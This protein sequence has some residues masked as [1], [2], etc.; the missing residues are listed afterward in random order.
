MRALHLRC[1]HFAP[2]LRNACSANAALAHSYGGGLSLRELV[3]RFAEDQDVAF[4]PKPGRT[5]AG[6]QVYSFGRVSVVI[7]AARE[8]LMAQRADGDRAWVPA[9]ME[10]LLEM[11]V[12]RSAAR[13]APA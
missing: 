12:G 3:E 7:D 4:L 10:Q 1:M 2:L 8:A 11:H 6:M 5:H 9:S 13:G